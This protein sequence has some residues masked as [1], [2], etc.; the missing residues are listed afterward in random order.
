MFP[1]KETL[2]FIIIFKVNTVRVKISCNEVKPLRVNLFYEHIHS[3]LK[4]LDPVTTY[5]IL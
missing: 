2:C 1:G 5:Y 3:M 4:Y